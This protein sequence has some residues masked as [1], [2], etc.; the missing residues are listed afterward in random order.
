MAV[1]G[2]K[3]GRATEADQWRRRSSSPKSTPELQQLLPRLGC[4]VELRLERQR[5]LQRL[6]GLVEFA[7]LQACLRSS[8]SANRP[9]RWVLC[10]RHSAPQERCRG[11]EAAA[12]LRPVGRALEFQGDLLVGSRGGHSQM[13]RTTVRIGLSIGRFRQRQ[14]HRAAILGRSRPIHCRAHQRMAEHHPP[15]DGQQSFRL[16]SLRVGEGDAGEWVEYESKAADGRCLSL[17]KGDAVAIRYSRSDPSV[18]DIPTGLS[19]AD[20][21]FDLR[22]DDNDE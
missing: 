22:E 12:R 3:P 14:V 9:P 13:P 4:A 8:Q 20:G 15:A 17:R 2:R 19:A 1:S 21:R 10:Q 11:G 16:R 5:P 6:L 7:C 18:W